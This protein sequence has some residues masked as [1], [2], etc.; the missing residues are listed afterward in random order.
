MWGVLG[1]ASLDESAKVPRQQQQQQRRRKQAATLSGTTSA[2]SQHAKPT[3]KKSGVPIQTAVSKAICGKYRI[4][5]TMRK[6]ATGYLYSAVNTPQAED[7]DKKSAAGIGSA[8]GGVVLKV[9]ECAAPKRQMQTEWAVYRALEKQR[10]ATEG[11]TEPLPPRATGGFPQTEFFTSTMPQLPPHLASSSQY[12][13]G[14]GTAGG[15]AS[16]GGGGSGVH[17]VLVDSALEAGCA[18]NVLAMERLGDNLMSLSQGCRGGHFS[19]ETTL[20]LGAQMVGLLRML[21]NTGYV[22]RDIKPENFCVGPG[23]HSNRIY[24]IDYG[25]AC[26]AGDGEPVAA[27]GA[28]KRTIS[29]PSSG[30]AAVATTVWVDVGKVDP[31]RV[32][33]TGASAKAAASKPS[34][35]STRAKGV[36]DAGAD[37]PGDLIPPP[38]HKRTEKD[39]RPATCP[40]VDFNL[41]AGASGTKASGA[42][43]GRADERRGAGMVGSPAAA[44]E[45]D[46]GGGLMSSSNASQA[47]VV[48]A[49]LESRG[50]K[51][52][53]PPP[54]SGQTT[55][56]VG[57]VRYLS[58][59]AHSRGRQTRRCDLESL[60]YVLIYLVRGKLPWQGLT[61]KTREAHME[62]IRQSKAEET[63]E[64]LCR[65]LPA[66]AEYLTYV[67]GLEPGEPVDY[68]R[69]EL[70]FTDGLRRR[71]FSADV[72]FDWMKQNQA[73]H[74][75]HHHPAKV[76]T[77]VPN[78]T[79]LG[80]AAGKR[81]RD[82][83][84]TSSTHQQCGSAAGGAVGSAAGVTASGAKKRPRSG[85]GSLLSGS[86]AGGGRGLMPAAAMFDLYADVPPPEEKVP[87]SVEA[88]HEGKGVADISGAEDVKVSYPNASS[89]KGSAAT[90]LA[91]STEDRGDPV[92]ALVDI[93]KVTIRPELAPKT[94]AGQTA[95]GGPATEVGAV[96]TSPAGRGANGA[97][98]DVSSALG[99]LR[100]HLQGSRTGSKKFPRAC[101]LLT[102]L[103]CA[104]LDQEN[105]EIFFGVISDTVA[106]RGGC[107]QNRDV[108]AGEHLAL[109]RGNGVVGEAIRRLVAAASSRSSCFSGQRREAVESW[110]EEIAKCR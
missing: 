99:K 104:K 47:S 90:L 76:S 57:S 12:N 45:G 16:G 55:G 108:S 67:R 27:A 32:T 94:S 101:G 70:I 46:G 65:G 100:P 62:K 1:N 21:H 13:V 30:A 8:G 20:R 102:D 23:K 74:H 110:A 19:L 88:R 103:L 36:M 92:S 72:P 89:G 44:D 66:L 97:A 18:V 9:E 43:S 22:H 80:G 2:A 71:G 86:A 49:A 3:G 34:I 48:A 93:K 106:Y 87:A 83:S 15:G 73:H 82:A 29:T 109:L 50:T 33:P 64:T 25:L 38:P 69:A 96:G 81:T 37:S 5:G 31:T 14:D 39:G 42:V 53:P 78:G 26:L 79:V 35:G 40:E 60:A 61:A 24:L 68:Q 7:E 56:L 10:L 6:G 58:V 107:G 11:S 41:S 59:A 95:G 75:H 4:I 63:A 54:P 28:E 105:E 17:D 84:A 91:A 85:S 98:V 51:P 52:P 77:A